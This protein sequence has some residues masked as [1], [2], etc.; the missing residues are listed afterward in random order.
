MVKEGAF[1]EDLWYRMNIFPITIPPLRERK[2]DIP[3]L[4]HHFIEKKA[5]EMGLQPAQQL[6]EGT[7]ERLRNYHWPGNVRELENTVERALILSGGKPLQFNWLGNETQ[8]PGDRNTEG[9]PETLDSV[10]AA[11]IGKVLEYTGGKVGGPGGAASIL[12]LNSS[13]LRHRMKK[14]GIPYGRQ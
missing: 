8:R 3:A 11:H 14:L 5:L 6:S 1:R 13:T 4:V 9:K 7:M 10:V 12:G 2:A